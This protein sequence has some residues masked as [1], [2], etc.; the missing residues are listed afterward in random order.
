MGGDCLNVGCV[1][2]KALIGAARSW[3]AARTS[4]DAFGGP[5]STG[6]GRFAAAMERMRRLRA[7]ISPVDGAPRFRELGVDVFFGEGRFTSREALAVDGR[8]LPFRR[9]VIA[10]GSRPAR[11]PIPGLDATGYLTNETI[12]ALSELPARLLVLGAGP[13]GC[14]MAQAFARFGSRVTL[15]EQADQILPREDADAARLVERAMASHGVR[16]LRRVQRAPRGARGGVRV[17]HVQ[18]DGRAEAI[19]GE[20]LLVAVGRTPNVEGLGLEAA[21]VSYDARG[22][23][24]DDRLRTTNPRIFAVGDVAS[25]YRFTHA[26]DAQA[27]LVVANA[28]F[29]GLGGGKASRLVIPGST[30]TSPEVAHVGLTGPEAEAG[31]PRS[32]PSPSRCTRWIARCSTGRTRASFGSTC[33][34]APTGSS[35]PPWWPSTPAT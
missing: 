2:S 13:V 11:P 32:R 23:A 22:I 9:A 5:A 6:A 15:L 16:V 17:L 4:A 34:G 8:A 12:F 7:G 19:E 10:T 26:A 28:L 31:V 35:A 18:R 1:P 21:G 27:R 25:R 30:Y 33:G 14:E 3:Q 29:F 20:Q 24:V